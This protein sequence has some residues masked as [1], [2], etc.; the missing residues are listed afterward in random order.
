MAKLSNRT[1]AIVISAAVLLV[2]GI[3]L[4]VLVLT[5]PNSNAESSDTTTSQVS[6]AITVTDK[7]AESITKVTIKNTT[8]EYEINKTGE[9]EWEIPALG[10]APVNTMTISA[11]MNNLSAC[12][13]T[14]LVEANAENLEKYG[15]KEPVAEVKV[16]FDDG[17][18]SEMCLGILNNAQTYYYFAVKG[19]NDVHYVST[20]KMGSL[21]YRKEDFVATALV[22]SYDS[23]NPVVM[24]KMTITRADLDYPII[25]EALPVQEDDEE[26]ITTFND[27]KFTSPYAIEVDASRSSGVIYG[28]YGLTAAQCEYLTPTE[29]IL[30]KTGLDNPQ[31]VVSMV[32]NGKTYTLKIGEAIKQITL[33]ESEDVP[34]TVTITGYYAMLDGLDIVYSIAP[35]SL[36]WLNANVSDLMSRM[37]LSPYIYSLDTITVT[38]ADGAMEFKI[39]G[40]KDNYKFLYN[41]EAVD[42][43]KFK[44]LYQFMISTVGEELYSEEPTGELIASIRYTYKDKAQPDDS[45]E[46]YASDDR[47][48]I[49]KINGTTL[50]KVRQIYTTKLL[51]NI[52]ALLNGGDI[53]LEW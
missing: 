13:T 53:S 20:Y 19:S 16:D 38:T 4:V 6:T 11:L 32:T 34:D 39:D 22:E 36:P 37:P 23:S 43:A 47:K 51:A 2:L 28:M 41:G 50:Y 31:C 15:L 9:S 25:I 48:S 33:S 12:K 17:T 45:L 7:A 3:V 14:E 35:T 21:L 5:E 24:E 30:A 52:D 29:E 10:S 8:G 27:H 1:R 42:T 26:V 49:I 44:E 18:T 40:D 46:Y